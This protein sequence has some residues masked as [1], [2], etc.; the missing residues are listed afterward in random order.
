MNHFHHST[1]SD[2]SCQ[3]L[4]HCLQQI[5]NGK[6]HLKTL[7]PSS[8]TN[9]CGAALSFRTILLYA[10]ITFRQINV[11]LL[12]TYGPNA[13]RIHNYLL[14]STAKQTEKALEDLK[15]LTVEVNR[16]R[17]NSQVSGI[18]TSRGGDL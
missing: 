10:D 14:E 9:A 1:P 8:S 7:V 2:I 12:Q 4:H 17:K 13:W 6:L 18:A 3:L 5:K 11:T 16:E 15:Q